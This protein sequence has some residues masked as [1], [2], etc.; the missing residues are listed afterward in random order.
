MENQKVVRK[1]FLE[2]LSGYEGDLDED[3]VPALLEAARSEARRIEEHERNCRLAARDEE[4]N[5]ILTF[6]E[7]LDEL[8]DDEEG[9]A[10]IRIEFCISLLNRLDKEQRKHVLAQ[11]APPPQNDLS[12]SGSTYANER[13]RK[14]IPTV[15]RQRDSGDVWPHTWT[16]ER[17]NEWDSDV[18]RG[19]SGVS[20]LKFRVR[21]GSVDR[22]NY[23]GRVHLASTTGHNP[24]A[25]HGGVE[26]LLREIGIYEKYKEDMPTTPD[27]F[28][29]DQEDHFRVGWERLPDGT[30]SFV[31]IVSSTR[32]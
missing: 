1:M 13:E 7:R 16:Q 28:L 22:G 18:K 21:N 32:R 19:I 6:A 15:K 14:P 20:G 5:E 24:I 11:Y 30:R 23:S 17:I 3:I 26:R 8:K 2:L 31:K 4:V 29:F 27:V 10:E 25:V 9:F 12:V